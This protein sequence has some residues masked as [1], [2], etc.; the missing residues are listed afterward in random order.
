MKKWFLSFLRWGFRGSRRQGAALER[1]KFRVR[2]LPLHLELLEDRIVPALVTWN[3]QGDGSSWND[4]HNWNTGALPGAADDVVI[5][6]SPAGTVQF[7]QG[8]V[9]I[10][11]L[12]ENGRL[13]ITGGSLTATTGGTLDGGTLIDLAGSL[14]GTFTARNSSLTFG[15]S[16]SGS[17][18]FVLRQANTVSGVLPTGLTLW[19][20]GEFSNGDANLTLAGDLTNNGTIFMQSPNWGYASMLHSGNYT[21]TNSATGVIQVSRGA[22]GYRRFDGSL[23]NEGA[24]NIDGDSWIDFDAT[25][26]T[27]AGGTVSGPHRFRNSQIAETAAASSPTTLVLEQNN[28][29]LLT[30]NYPNTTLWV[31]G[32]YSNGDATLHLAASVANHGTLLLSAPNWGYASNVNTDGYTLTNAS[33]GLIQ[34]D[35]A[36]NGYRSINGNFVNSGAIVLN[37]NTTLVNALGGGHTLTLDGGTI[38]TGGGGIFLAQDGAVQL[39]DTAINGNFWLRNAS[40]NIAADSTATGTVVFQRS[41]TVSGVVPTGLTLW[42]QGEYSNGDANLTLAGDLT[43]NGTIFMQSPNWGYAS[44]LHGGNYTLTNAPSGVIHVARGANGYRRFDGS[45]V[46][47][48]AINIDGDTWLD[49]NGALY[50]SAGGTVNGPHRFV[51]SQIAETAAASSPTTLV[52]Q[53]NNN[54]LLTD[55]YPNT[56]LWV[57]GEYSNGDATLTVVGNVTN[58]GTILLQSPNAGYASALNIINTLHNAGVLDIE[59]GAGGA[60]YLT[61]AVGGSFIN[62]VAGQMIGSGSLPVYNIAFDSGGSI[63]SN[64][65]ITEP[66]RVPGVGPLAA[67]RTSLPSIVGDGVNID[68]F[69]GI[70][71]GVPSP[72]RVA[73]LTPN[74]VFQSPYIRFP[75]PGPIVHSP[76]TFRSFFAT[77]TV[78]PAQIADQVAGRFTLRQTFYLAVGQEMDKDPNTAGITIS[79]GV[80]SDDGYWLQ[81]G[82][83]FIGSAGD[84]GFTYNWADINFAQPGLYPIT[85]FYQEN[86]GDFGEQL[87]WNTATSNG[88]QIIPQTAL[89]T[90]TRL[91][92]TLITFEEVATGTL[93]T[94]Q[95]RAQGVLFNRTGGN[96]QVTSANPSQFVPVSGTRVYADPTSNPAQTGQV[97]LTFV[98]TGTDTPASTD[99]VSLYVINAAS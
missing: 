26:Y 40:L 46:N 80:G 85:L 34:V 48:G 12:R 90:T 56:T 84:R 77:T 30:D 49:F 81:V 47:E 71:S 50:T 68:M 91:G 22:G 83:F 10:N 16:A 52:L 33:D 93:L 61:G 6:A 94:D 37:G 11:S 7:S 41:N 38:T 64:I 31:Q 17:T 53:Q 39:Q 4:P 25:V 42:V 74:V 44:I 9:T 63:S 98:V 70:G 95:Y 82:P 23:V 13:Q 15:A 20:Q 75:N 65:T 73:G 14:S 89:Y 79:L 36:A 18:Y 62:D 54:T 97:E 19:V 67:G 2:R 35:Q 78:P 43:N 8:T 60:R 87:S 55:N 92:D 86:G 72:D 69:T 1:R 66:G 88:N 76:S 3:G 59:P 5:N 28:N 24:I 58:S 21:L 45:L 99:F 32:E 96:L 29:T 27:S 51:N 57:Q